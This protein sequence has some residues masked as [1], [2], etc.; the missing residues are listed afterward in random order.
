MHSVV[1]PSAHRR[2]VHR[3]EAV[4][5][6]RHSRR[7]ESALRL[8]FDLLEQRVVLASPESDL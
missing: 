8:G 6:Q 2:A 5:R 4:A 3:S 7:N 1:A